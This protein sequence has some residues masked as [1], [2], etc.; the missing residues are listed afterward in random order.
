M[1]MAQSAMLANPN[2]LARFL[3]LFMALFLRLSGRQTPRRVFMHFRQASMLRDLLF[4]TI[5]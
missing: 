4:Q 3:E 2:P 1:G 5:G